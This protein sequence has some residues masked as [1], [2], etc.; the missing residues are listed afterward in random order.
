M[1]GSNSR[2][3]EKGGEGR[4]REEKQSINVVV[5]LSLSSALV[6]RR[7]RCWKPFSTRPSLPRSPPPGDNFILRTVLA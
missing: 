5:V 2:K 7:G 3:E 1:R 6:L 4:R